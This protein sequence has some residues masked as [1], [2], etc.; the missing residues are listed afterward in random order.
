RLITPLQQDPS[1]QAPW[2]END[3][4]EVAH[5]SLTPLLPSCGN[6]SLVKGGPVRITRTCALKARRAPPRIRAP[7]GA[8]VDEPCSGVRRAR[9]GTRAHSRRARSA[10]RGVEA[11]V[12]V[13]GAA[14]M[15]KSRL[16][17]EVGAIARS[18]GI[19]VG[20]SAADPSETVVE[21]AAL[22]AA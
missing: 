15:G 17:A 7:R 12:I 21:L 20:T 2:H 19:K 18:L 13:E 4:R 16:V 5:V 22:L 6:A 8:D 1:A 11:V 9:R 14:G 10:F 3:V